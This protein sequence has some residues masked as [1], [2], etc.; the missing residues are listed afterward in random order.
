MPTAPAKSSSKQSNS[1]NKW[2]ATGA[3]VTV[4]AGAVAAF[5]FWPRPVPTPKTAAEVMKLA[6]TDKWSRLTPEQLE[7]IFKAGD[8]MSWAERMQAFA[9]SGL[10]D[11]ERRRAMENLGS[12]MMTRQARNYVKLSPEDRKKELDR[13]IDQQEAMRRGMGAMTGMF[14][15]TTR[16]GGSTGG[17]PGGPGGRGGWSNPS[18]QKSRLESVPPSDRAAMAQMF[19]DMAQR[20]AERGLPGWGGPGGGGGNASGGGSGRR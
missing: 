17:P 10:S 1:K 8:N 11:D 9:N 4:L 3:A 2:I 5:A 14:R 12:G 7:E 13:Q 19:G 6:A 20:R 16:P 15:P 18:L